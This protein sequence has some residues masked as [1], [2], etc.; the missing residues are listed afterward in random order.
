MVQH[1]TLA[2][3]PPHKLRRH[4]KVLCINENVVGEIEL[5]ER[6]NPAQE[7]RLQKEP[8]IRFRLN[9]MSYAHELGILCKRSKLGSHIGGTEINPAYN[10]EN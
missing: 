10:S 8:I 7:V 2:R 9:N 4:L 1:K 5:F 3:K 6:R